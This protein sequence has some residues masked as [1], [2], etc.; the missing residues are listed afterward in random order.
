MFVNITTNFIKNLK[1]LEALKFMLAI[2]SF[3]NF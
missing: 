3:P 1:T 2:I